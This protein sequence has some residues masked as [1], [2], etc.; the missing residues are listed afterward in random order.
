MNIYILKKDLTDT[1][2]GTRLFFQD[3]MYYYKTNTEQ[4][5]FLTIDEVENNSELYRPITAMEF[6]FHTFQSNL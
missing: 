2:A 4:E 1:K 5:K 6:R 3:G